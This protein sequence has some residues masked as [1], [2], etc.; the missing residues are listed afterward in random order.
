VL[1]EI[2]KIKKELEGKKVYIFA[3]DSYAHN[4]AS[5]VSDLGLEIAGVTTLHHDMK[6]DGEDSDHSTLKEMIDVAGDIDR[7]TVC[8]KQAL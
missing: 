2:E 7:F 1:P 4:I 5:V 8:N 3:G 6:T